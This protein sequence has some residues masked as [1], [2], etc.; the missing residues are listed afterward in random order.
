MLPLADHLEMAM[1]HLTE[2]EGAGAA[3]VI[4]NMEAVQRAFLDT[5]RRYG[6]TPIDALGRP[7]D[8]NLHEAVGQI[9]T[10]TTPP[11]AVAAVVQTGYQEGERLLRPARVLVNQGGG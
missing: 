11:G 4:G 5:L 10:D 8:P 2:Q 9:H 7:F 1:K 3:S 6:V